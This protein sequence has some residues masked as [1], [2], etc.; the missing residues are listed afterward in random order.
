MYIINLIGSIVETKI[1]ILLLFDIRNVSVICPAG[2]YTDREK[3]IACD[4]GTYQDKPNQAKCKPCPTGSTT[5]SALSKHRTDCIGEFYISF[6]YTNTSS[7]FQYVQ[8]S[9]Q[10]NS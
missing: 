3:C 7:N 1:D 10:M 6:C 5:R 9:I 2:M 8:Y 4:V